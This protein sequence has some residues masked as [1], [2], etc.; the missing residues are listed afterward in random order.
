MT[1]RGSGVFTGTAADYANR[2]RQGGK[3]DGP[4]LLK[5]GTGEGSQV[6]G[7]GLY[8]STVRG[9]A[10]GYAK[11]DAWTGKALKTKSGLVKVKAKGSATVNFRLN[12]RALSKCVKFHPCAVAQGRDGKG[13]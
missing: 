5:V 1:N 12:F 2:S 9:V 3:D 8:G 11:R 6:Y 7:W 10:E 4:S 13:G